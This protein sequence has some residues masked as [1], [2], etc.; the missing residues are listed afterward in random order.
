[1]AK[2]K[3]IIKLEGTIGDITFFKTKDGYMAREHVPLSADRIASDPAFQRTRENNQEFGRAGKA[4]KLLRAAFRSLLLNTAD[5]RMVS[6]LTKEMMKV[7][8]ADATS[9]RGQRNVLDGETELLQGFE[10]NEAGKLSTT[11]FMPFT[12]SINRG[13]GSAQVSLP[14]YTPL[15]SITAPGGA[16]HY[17][18]LVA[19]A[20][21]NFEA[22][23]YNMDETS[24][25]ELALDTALV[26]AASF[27]CTLA[28][29]A[30]HPIFLLLGIEFF[31]QVNGAMYSL[32][33]GAFNA[34][35]VV[36]VSGS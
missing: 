11:L 33:N 17:R 20:T 9:S 36:A 8:Q 31:Q 29:A 26:P 3:S 28:A 23:T 5:N 34:L 27:T 18:L 19:A 2:Q 32:K 24:T 35:Q 1:M 6:R 30:T 10:F 7:I 13:T 25:A 15:N 4:G 12:T 16:T 14:E 22:G 21:V